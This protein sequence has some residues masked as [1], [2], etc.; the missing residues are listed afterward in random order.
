RELQLNAR[1]INQLTISMPIG[2]PDKKQ[3]IEQQIKALQ[4]KNQQ[5][6]QDLLP[7]ALDSFDNF[8]NTREEIT[9]FLL[10]HLQ[11]QLTGKQFQKIPFNPFEAERFYK[12]LSDAGVEV[13][14]LSLMG[15]R[16]SYVLLDIEL[17]KNRLIDA[18]RKGAPVQQEMM[19]DLRSLSEKFNEEIEYRK[20]DRQN[21]CSQVRIDTDQGAMLVEL[22][23]DQSPNTV[24][25]FIALVESGFYDGK[26]FYQ[27][28]PT[29]VA[30]AG[31]SGNDGQPETAFQIASEASDNSRLHFSGTL[32]MINDAQGN[33]D[34]RF[35][36]A[37]QTS[38]NFDGKLSSFGRII[39]GME[40]L[41]KLEVVDLTRGQSGNPQPATVIQKM[42]VVKKRDK[43][44]QPVRVNR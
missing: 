33:T 18:A 23:E 42:T 30:I 2:F 21:N 27:V 5:I 11:A 32:T 14:S 41:Y 10:T 1:R 35:L 24:A 43:E 38:P 12:K 25:N 9:G 7:T 8:P 44:Y 3:Q 28:N 36:I 29:Q 40:N 20:A 6:A 37:K 17:A 16:T 39:E 15:Y 31:S 26:K 34:S 13:P 22:F 19:T 4:I